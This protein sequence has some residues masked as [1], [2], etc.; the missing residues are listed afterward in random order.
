MSVTLFFV[1]FI[2]LLALTVPIGACFAGIAV[3]PNLL[4]PAAYGYTVQAAISSMVNNGLNSFPILAVPLFMLSGAIMAKGGISRKLFNFFAY[5]IGDKRAGYP[6]TVIITCLF[7]GAISGSGPATVTA[8]GS[9]TIPLLVELGYDFAWSTAIVSISG[10]LGI[11]IPPSIAYVI[12]ANSSGSSTGDLFIAGILPGCLIAAFMCIYT[13]CYCRKTGEDREKLEINFKK[14]RSQGLWSLFKDCFWALLTPVIILGTI[15][16]GIC[17]PTESAAISVVYALL[18]SLFAY[19]S[20]T[21][22]DII[23]SLR[24]AVA[25]Y[26]PIL[27]VIAGS[28]AFSRVITLMQVPAIIC[29]AVLGFAHG[30][31]MVLLIVNIVL[32]IAGMILDT[33]PA[34]IILTP[35]LW[36]IAQSVGMDLIHFGIIM[37]CNLTIGQVTPPM[38]INLFVA[39]TLTKIPVLTIAKKVLP[40]IVVFLFAL[41]FV[42]AIPALSL[43][44]I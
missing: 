21:V 9:M 17:S 11:I 12:F 23:P 25:S 1:V 31:V 8:V 29:D 6:C 37:T 40:Y 18:V 20:M 43:C 10:G 7:F 2:V 44:L 26:G 32:L 38:G 24:D 13:Y 14:V 28:T 36:P 3:L 16:G 39:S 27:F 34:I 33:I 35:I 30:K 22:K 4:D 5:F 42:N 41:I 15:Y 19:K